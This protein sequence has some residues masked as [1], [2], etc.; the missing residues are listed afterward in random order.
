MRFRMLE[1]AIPTVNYLRLRGF[2]ADVLGL[3]IASEGRSHVF[4]E[5]A[6]G[7]L[8]VVDASRGD[9]FVRPTGH[10][11]YLDLAVDDLPE[12]RRRLRA[13]GVALLDDRRD[14]HGIALT[15]TDPEGNLINLFQ[16]GSF[17]ATS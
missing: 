9:A 10:G 7:R 14:E 13:A 15:F 2:Y 11:I 8:A 4:F 1:A 6:G 16:E 3:P 5:V 12:V 17:S